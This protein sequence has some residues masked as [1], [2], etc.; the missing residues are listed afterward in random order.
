MATT[1]QSLVSRLSLVQSEAGC[2]ARA[3]PCPTFSAL[4]VWSRARVGKRATGVVA[5]DDYLFSSSLACVVAA[6]HR[7]ECF[8]RD[9][10]G[11]S[12]C[13]F[14]DRASQRVVVGTPLQAGW[15]HQLVDGP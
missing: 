9:A 4:P 3:L 10:G 11:G 6:E 8:A 1:A 7:R 12:N 14:A 5:A 15:R 2:M 13:G